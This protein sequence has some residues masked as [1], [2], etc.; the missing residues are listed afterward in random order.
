MKTIIAPA[1]LIVAIALFSFTPIDTTGSGASVITLSDGTVIIPS[2][3][4]MSVSD[5]QAILSAMTSLGSDVG[6]LCYENTDGSTGTYNA[7]TSSTALSSVDADYGSD[8][9]SGKTGTGWIFY[10]ENMFTG[11]INGTYFISSAKAS[12]LHDRVASILEKYGY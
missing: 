12:Q 5:Q 9:S 2:D 3:V 4:N 6:Y 11:H 8:L 10:E 7:P 1:L